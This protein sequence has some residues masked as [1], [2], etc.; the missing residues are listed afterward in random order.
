MALNTKSRE[1]VY[2]IGRTVPELLGCKLPSLRMALG[3]F[4]HYH[5]ELHKTVRHSS[6]A[7]I[8]EIA[9]FWQKARIPIGKHTNCKKKIGKDF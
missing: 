4:L 9:K 3:S 1:K 6:N 5:L 8:L 2:L 7:T